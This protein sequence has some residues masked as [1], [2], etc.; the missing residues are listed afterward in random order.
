MKQAAVQVGSRKVLPTRH[1]GV[2][3]R[4]QG[5]RWERTHD[6]S[7]FDYRSTFVALRPL[8]PV[9]KR[10][11]LMRYWYRLEL[12]T[13][14]NEKN[15]PFQAPTSAKP[16]ET[17]AWSAALEALSTLLMLIQLTKLSRSFCMIGY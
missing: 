16:S 9:R 13:A 12:S 1:L 3:H 4:C 6:C 10:P 5:S 8:N 7:V 15:G 11:E 17:A 2:R 14:A